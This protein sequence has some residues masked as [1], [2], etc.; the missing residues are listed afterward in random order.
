MFFFSK[1]RNPGKTIFTFDWEKWKV[2]KG[3]R[4][5]ILQLSNWITSS[6]KPSLSFLRKLTIHSLCSPGMSLLLALYYA[7]IICLYLCLGEK[8]DSILRKKMEVF[9][10]RCLDQMGLHTCLHF[11]NCSV[12]LRLSDIHG[13]VK[14][15]HPCFKRSRDIAL[16]I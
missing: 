2:L 6:S 11:L 5:C 16:W 12:A 9:F 7:T 15:R 4:L 13:R 14:Q 3:N 1:K 8:T 10:C